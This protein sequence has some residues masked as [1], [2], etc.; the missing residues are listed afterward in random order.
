MPEERTEDTAA[1]LGGRIYVVGGF[2]GG[3]GL[4]EYD[5][6]TDQWRQRAKPPLAVHHA[7]A[8]AA[9]GRLYV[10]GGYSGSWDPM[11]KTFAYDP[12]SDQWRELRPI[13]SARGALAVALLD[14]RI[15]AVGG[16]G[17]GGRNSGAHEVYDPASDRWVA[18]RALPTPRD[19]LAAAAVNG[20]LYAIGGRLDGSY[21][22]NLAVNEEYDPR[23]GQSRTHAP[24]PPVRTRSS[25]HDQAARVG[26]TFSPKSC[27]VRRGSA[28]RLTVNIT[29][30]APAACAART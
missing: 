15:H 10:V 20:R 9:G 29:R 30:R 12:A 21:A 2:G 24:L 14:D 16:V 7:G 8:V 27:T 11:N 22:R 5:A 3:G 1:A 13:P 18:A 26:S 6:A 19:H 28:A 25:D 23:T 4:L 17:V